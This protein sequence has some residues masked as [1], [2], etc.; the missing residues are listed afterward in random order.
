MTRICGYLRLLIDKVQ[1]VFNLPCFGPPWRRWW[2]TLQSKIWT[3]NDSNHIATFMSLAFFHLVLCFVVNAD[4][5][6]RTVFLNLEVGWVSRFG[7][8]QRCDQGSG[9]VDCRKPMARRKCLPFLQL[10]P[11]VFEHQLLLP[12]EIGTYFYWSCVGY[13]R[14]IQHLGAGHFIGNLPCMGHYE[15]NPPTYKKFIEK[16]KCICTNGTLENGL[17]YLYQAFQISVIN[18]STTH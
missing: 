3:G 11:G 10:E 18:A 7:S 15:I 4:R 1:L 12:W 14:P 2:L 17:M 9:S 5:L 6:Q 16:N 8:R 13:F